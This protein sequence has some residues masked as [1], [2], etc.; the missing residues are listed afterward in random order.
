MRA[1]LRISSDLADWAFL[2]GTAVVVHGIATLIWN[3]N[4]R[5]IDAS[6]AS[7]LSNLEPFI[8][9]IMGLL[10]LYKPSQV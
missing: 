1:P 4:I 10:L 7:I 6:K 9:L 3:N 8:A 2:A 5:H